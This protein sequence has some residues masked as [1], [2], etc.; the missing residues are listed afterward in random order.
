MND[1]HSYLSSIAYG[2]NPDTRSLTL[3]TPVTNHST[4]L[5]GVRNYRLSDGMHGIPP[6]KW[7]NMM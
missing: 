7:T 4:R 3:S 6:L 5:Q 1:S 2:L